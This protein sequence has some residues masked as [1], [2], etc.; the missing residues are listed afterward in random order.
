MAIDDLEG[1][2]GDN[3]EDILN[4]Q[5]TVETNTEILGFVEGDIEDL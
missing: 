2:V 3:E 1:D 4:L 5:S